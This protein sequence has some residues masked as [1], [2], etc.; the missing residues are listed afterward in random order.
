MSNIS[1]KRIMLAA[2]RSGSGK[3]TMTCAL[4]KALQDR[5]LAPVSFKCGPDY[6]DPLFHG[7]VLGIES[8]NLDTYFSGP[9]GVCEILSACE[10]EYAVIEGVMGL[11]DGLSANGTKGSAYEIAELTRTPIVLIV[12]ASS[13]G[14]TVLS[15]IKGV[16]L[17]D[18]AHLIRGV[19]LNKI[20]GHFFE[21]LKPAF[22]K[23]IAKLGTDVQLL[24]YF[25]KDENIGIESRHL[26]LHLP[27]E[28]TDL[29]EK[30]AQAAN[31]LEKNA[32]MDALLAIMEQTKCTGQ[33]GE[34]CAGQDILHPDTGNL[35][36]AGL[37]LA[38]ANDD[39]FCFYYG[40]NLDQF[41]KRGV[42]IRYFSPLK[43]TCLPE[44][45]CGILFGGGYPENH[46]KELSANTAM[47]RSVRDAIARGVPS[48][49]ECGGFMYLHRSV[50][51]MDGNDYEMA[52]L[53]DGT[54]AYAGHLVRF[55]YL[56]IRAVDD[57]LGEDELYHGLVGMRGHEF[58]YFDNTADT[59]ACTAAKPDGKK[60]RNCMIMQNNGIW[61]FPHFYYASAPAFIDRFVDRMREFLYHGS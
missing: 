40:D 47:L 49:A 32:D 1:T 58:H 9:E 6:I 44:D 51:G 7:K 54:C 42:K 4:L 55:G 38:V 14:R 3:T 16:L 18:E 11:Y 20:S 45:T 39:A 27:D 17:D 57:R 19:I 43:D 24:G 21:T 50:T 23:E 13:V 37:T 35:P 56:E 31:L 10:S 22:E 2:P 28:I 12:D 48:L 15:L 41:R 46:L 33:A 25:P 30:I 53:I 59:S 29:K 36:G 5:G 34:P 26:G 61:G 52:G 8:R 60:I